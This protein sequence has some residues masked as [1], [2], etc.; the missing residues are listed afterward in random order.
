M[1]LT[2]LDI[3][4]KEF[5]VSFRG[6]NQDEVNEFLRQ[7][8]QEFEG[9]IRE[10][11]Q[12]AEQS[13]LLEERLAHFS[14]LE[15]SLSK[16]IVVAQE[17]AE[18]VKANARKEAQLIVRE[19]E[20]NADRIVNEALMKSRKILMEMEE[21]QKQVSVFRTRLRSLVQAQLEMIEAR[22]WDDLAEDLQQAGQLESG[23]GSR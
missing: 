6:Y 22:D 14:N 2:P 11:K 3:H 5:S 17:A 10:N 16:S 15:E 1:S 8:I 13:R 12:L 20:K 7:V 21:I 18:E 4:N 19:A 23:T 9:L